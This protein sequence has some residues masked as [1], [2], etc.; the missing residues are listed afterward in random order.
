MQEKRSI[1]ARFPLLLYDRLL[2]NMRIAT[3]VLRHYKRTYRLLEGLNPAANPWALALPGS[4]EPRGNIIVFPGSFNPPTIAHLAMLRQA[5][6]FARRQGGHAW[7]IYAALSKFSVD[8]ETVERMTLLDRVVLLENVLRSQG[9]RVGVLLLNRG[10]YVE[11][12]RGMRAA[13]PQVR[14]L[15][16]LVGFDKIVQILDPHYYTERDA[17]LRELFG[18]ASLLVAPRATDGKEALAALL[19]RPE[20]R[21]FARSIRPLPLEERYRNISSSQARQDQ[22][23][24]TNALPTRVRNFIAYTRPYTAPSR[25]T[26]EIDFYAKRMCSLQALFTRAWAGR[27]GG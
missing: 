7:Q 8:K 27:S 18:M 26:P 19:A 1:S 11:Q 20:N 13:F 5:H 4:P 12:A 17:A 6:K 25:E 23:T 24:Q 10:L 2:A 21:P 14:N 15:F 22:D 3:P 16:F 9:Q